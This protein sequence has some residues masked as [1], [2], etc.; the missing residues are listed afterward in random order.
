MTAEPIGPD[1]FKRWAPQAQNA[2]LARL[3]A[4][5][6]SEYRPFYCPKGAASGCNGLP[7]DEW[8]WNHARTDQHPPKGD[9]LTWLQRGG[10]GS[11]K[12]RTGSQWVHKIT[13][14]APFISIIAP[15]SADARDTL[16]EGESGLLATAAPGEA[17]E[18]EPSKRRLT[19]PNGSRATLF[20]GEEPDRLR[21]QNTF[22]AWLDEPAHIA[23]IEDVW[24]NLLFGLRKGRRPRICCTTTPLP[25]PWIKALVADQSTVNT[26]VPTMSNIHNLSPVFAAEIMRRY[27]G[28]RKGRQELHGE[29]IDDVEG[30][31]WDSEMFEG[32]NGE[33]RVLPQDLP[34]MDRIVVSIDPAGTARRKSDETGIVVAGV[35]DGIVYVLHD[36]SGKMTPSTWANKALSLYEHY[37]ADSIV[38]EQTYGG[39]MVVRNLTASVPTGTMLPRIEKPS[40]R[41][42]KVLRAEPVVALYEQGRVRHVAGTVLNDLEDQMVTWVPTKGYSPDRVDALVHAVTA[43]VSG[44]AESGIATPA[45]RDLA[46]GQTPAPQ[47][48]RAMVVALARSVLGRQMGPFG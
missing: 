40:T 11:G 4:A 37:S 42:G 19:W 41:R 1:A 23:L 13:K 39:D 30:A 34:V 28:T 21:G 44:I 20:S 48:S 27:E 3:D 43:L 16:V 31:L 36:A 47:R 32:E 38:A 15:T 6:N 35:S 9:W 24:S 29:I 7:H 26:V 25:I 10:R 33:K 5:R 46:T 22:A 8:Q 12:T 45:R 14:V 2:A 18:F 17:P